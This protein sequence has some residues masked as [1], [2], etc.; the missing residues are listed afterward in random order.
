MTKPQ[1][2]CELFQAG[3]LVWVDFLDLQPRRPAIYM[4]R[5]DQ[6]LFNHWSRALVYLPTGRRDIVYVS[7]LSVL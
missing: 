4:G 5:Y 1:S 2:S 6:G 7:Q 3:D